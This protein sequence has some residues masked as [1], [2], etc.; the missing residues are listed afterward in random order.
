MKSR[1][2][3]VR[4][5]VETNLSAQSEKRN[6]KNAS[7]SLGDRIHLMVDSNQPSRNH[8]EYDDQ[9]VT[10]L[11]APAYNYNYEEEP[12]NYNE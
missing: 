6:A 9:L 11:N 5:R 12:N 3:K 2:S 4:S 10:D 7:T 1:E 8:K